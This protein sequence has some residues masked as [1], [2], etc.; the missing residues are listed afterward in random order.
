MGLSIAFAT[1]TARPNAPA[2]NKSGVHEYVCCTGENCAGGVQYM[3]AWLGKMWF[4]RTIGMSVLYSDNRG[5]GLSPMHI[6][7]EQA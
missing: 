2:V 4:V 7:G 3:G 5:L 6:V 1:R